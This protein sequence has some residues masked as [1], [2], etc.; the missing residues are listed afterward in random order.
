MKCRR[1]KSIRT[2]SFFAKSKLSLRVLF[3][4]LYLYVK[5]ISLVQTC[6][7]LG[8]EVTHK[9]VLQWYTYYREITSLFLRDHKIKF[10]TMVSVVQL[11]E[12]YIGHQPKYFRG[13]WRGQQYMVL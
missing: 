2:G 7:L 6:K 8:N 9:S 11:D 10:G 13:A 1:K 3:T 5:D 12:S 4:I